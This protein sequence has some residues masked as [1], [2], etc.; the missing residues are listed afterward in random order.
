MAQET[1]VQWMAR[2]FGIEI[3]YKVEIAEQMEKEQIIK[4]FTEGG[5]IYIDNIAEESSPSAE[6]YYNE[7]YGKDI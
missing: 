2:V 5:R 1:A 6:D 3:D 7:T 4:S